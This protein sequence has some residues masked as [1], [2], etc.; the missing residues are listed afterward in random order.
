MLFI[1]EGFNRFK[2][3]ADVRQSDPQKTYVKTINKQINNEQKEKQTI[4]TITIIIVIIII[5]AKL[6]N[7]K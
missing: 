2:R 1:L 6:R 5:L 7:N 4:I 3:V